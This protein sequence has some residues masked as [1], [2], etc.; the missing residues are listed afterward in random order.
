VR[1]SDFVPAIA[2]RSQDLPAYVSMSTPDN[3]YYVGWDTPSIMHP[4]TL[5]AYEMNGAPLKPEH[6]APLRLA[7]PTKYCFKKI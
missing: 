7:S 6:G 3:Q 2:E 4:Q 1:F 5:L